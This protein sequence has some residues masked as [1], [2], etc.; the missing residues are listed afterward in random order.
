MN[1]ESEKPTIMVVDDTPANPDLLN[2][3]T[4]IHW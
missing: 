3:W 4:I 2:D 1:N